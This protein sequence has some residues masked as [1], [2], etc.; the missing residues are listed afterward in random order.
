M[1]V[2][3]HDIQCIHNTRKRNCLFNKPAILIK[4]VFFA[5]LSVIAAFSSTWKYEEKLRKQINLPH[6][7]LVHWIFTW[8]FLQALIITSNG[9]TTNLTRFPINRSATNNTAVT[10]QSLYDNNDNTFHKPVLRI[11]IHTRLSDVTP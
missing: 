3:N 10:S 6:V 11:N 7:F 4:F 8:V 9:K 2:M 1:T 5:T